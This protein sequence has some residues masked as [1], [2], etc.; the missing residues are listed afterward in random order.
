MYANTVIYE[1]GKKVKYYINQA[2]GY[3][4]NAKKSKAFIVYMN[5][6][7][8]KVGRRTVVEPGSHII[9]PSKEKGSG[10]SWEKILAFT[11]S[12]GSLATMAATIGALFR[13]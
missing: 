11:S 12:F 1:P 13:K 6:Q 10:V 7:V 8:S 5:G 4:T 9:V 3:G 2:G